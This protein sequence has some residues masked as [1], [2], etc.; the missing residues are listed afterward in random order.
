MYVWQFGDLDFNLF[1]KF[2]YIKAIYTSSSSQNHLKVRTAYNS[3]S[4]S[5]PQ[6]RTLTVNFKLDG[7]DFTRAKTIL[8][9]DYDRKKNEFR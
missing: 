2:V 9:V 6:Y 3:E 1:L 8:A 7:S 5:S 4:R